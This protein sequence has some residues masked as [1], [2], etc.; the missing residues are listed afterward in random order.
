MN[1]QEIIEKIKEKI[2]EAKESNDFSKI[3]FDLTNKRLNWLEQYINSVDEA[4]IV[5][6]AFLLLMK[7]LEVDLSEVPI[8]YEDDNR[9][10]FR[11]YNWCPVLEACKDLDLDT[12]EICRKGWEDSVN[13]FVKK[14][15]P[16]LR[17]S[18]DYNKLRPHGDFC[19]ETIEL[20]Y[21]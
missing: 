11:S 20:K 14:I 1:K 13:A 5:K 9:I 15:H 7:K 16:K 12:R 21:L 3:N 19:E 10:T 18:R 6:K 8:I 17:F 4:S 2:L